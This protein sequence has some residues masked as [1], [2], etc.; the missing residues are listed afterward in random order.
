[1]ECL[2]AITI[3]FMHK[4]L[5]LKHLNIIFQTGASF[6]I[7]TVHYIFFIFSSYNTAIMI[8]L[9]YKVSF[10]AIQL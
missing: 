5:F 3:N 7:H 9:I 2:K 4:A 6:L 8:V 1:M 10:N